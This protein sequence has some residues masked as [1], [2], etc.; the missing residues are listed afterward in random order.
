MLVG[1]AGNGKTF[2]MK[3]AKRLLGQVPDVLPQISASVETPQAWIRGMVGNDKTDP[4]VPPVGRFPVRWTDGVVRDTHCTFILAN[5]FI[6]YISLQEKEWV[7]AL[8]DIYDEDNYHYKTLA[9]SS[10]YVTGPYVTMLAAL[11]T[12]VSNDLQKTRIIST[13]MARRTLFQYGERL[14]H[15]PVAVPT[16][17]PEQADAKMAAVIRLNELTKVSGQFQWGQG[18]LDWWTKWYNAH[19]V[20][21]PKKSPQTK[22][23]FA[24]KPIQV[25]K[26]AM[27]TSLADDDDLIVETEDIQ[28]ALEQLGNLEMDLH[29]I[30]GGSGRNELSGIGVKIT[31]FLV[32]VRE[33]VWWKE[34]YNHTFHMFDKRNPMADFEAVITHLKDTDQV[35][36]T[37][38]KFRDFSTPVRVIGTAQVIAAFVEKNG[39]V[40]PQPPDGVPSA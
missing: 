18:T 24:S 6:N 19:S 11:T 20:Q 36:D 3:K 9:Q 22:S 23:W 4:P 14:W 38:I 27:L 34:L 33:P 15:S 29:R 40:P 10:I 25:L 17:T 1:D 37:T 32:G 12:E 21:V 35:R 26:I 39:T 30:F 28:L 16:F 13:G 7:N 5:E 8:N 2:A 31:E